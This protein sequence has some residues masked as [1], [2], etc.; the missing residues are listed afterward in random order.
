MPDRDVVVLSFYSMIATG[1]QN[2]P[3]DTKFTVKKLD[4]L[5]FKWPKIKTGYLK[6]MLKIK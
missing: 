5:G 4:E 1:S 2:I 6:H 3:L